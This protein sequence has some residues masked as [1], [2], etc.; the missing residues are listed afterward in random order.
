MRCNISRQRIGDRTAPSCE[1]ALKA[2]WPCLDPLV[3][4][5]DGDMLS[6]KW[7]LQ[8]DLSP[9]ECATT[10]SLAWDADNDGLGLFDE[11]RYCTDPTNPDTDGDG[12][13]DGDE[14]PHRPLLPSRPTGQDRVPF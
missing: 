2:D 14:V 4:D 13:W 9:C 6:D 8:H 3:W 12:V 10:N 5:S 7:E 11:Y 1:I